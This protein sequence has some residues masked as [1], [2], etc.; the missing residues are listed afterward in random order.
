MAQPEQGLL[1]G[2][3]REE[4]GLYGGESYPSE[5]AQPAQTIRVRDY[6]NGRAKGEKRYQVGALPACTHLQPRD[7]K[8]VRAD[9][10]NRCYCKRMHIVFWR[11]QIH[12]EQ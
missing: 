8:N 3:P 12:I 10:G 9:L 2:I 7:F 1:E 4:S 6:K 11:R 5:G